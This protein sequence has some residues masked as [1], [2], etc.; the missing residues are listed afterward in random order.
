VVCSVT[1]SSVYGQGSVTFS[2][3]LNQ[4]SWGSCWYW[5]VMFNAE[6]GQLFIVNWNGTALT[7]TSLDLYIVAQKSTQETWFCDTG[8]VALYSHSA[9]FGSVRWAAPA[10]GDYVIF[11]V[12]NNF[13]SGNSISGALSMT[14]INGTLTPTPIGY[15]TAAQPPQMN[16]GSV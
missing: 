3:S 6:P 2:F 13:N 7:P 1:V 8:P 11:L 10:A 14:A 12:N 4:S 16:G 5:D 9:M 15:A